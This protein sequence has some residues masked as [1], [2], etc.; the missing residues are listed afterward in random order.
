[1][2]GSGLGFPAR[3]QTNSIFMFLSRSK[4]LRTNHEANVL[5]L[6][7]LL[8]T[9]DE[10]P[11]HKC[12]STLDKRLA[13]LIRAAMVLRLHQPRAR[14][15]LRREDQNLWSLPVETQTRCHRRCR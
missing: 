11:T 15:P 13:V 3:S 4:Y 5:L 6:P 8:Q 2:C 14:K 1:M 9:R 7:Q 10:R 12:E